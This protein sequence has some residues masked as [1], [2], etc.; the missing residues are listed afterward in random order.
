MSVDGLSAAGTPRRPVGGSSF[1]VILSA[2]PAIGWPEK[3][4]S[5]RA[6]P[7]GGRGIIGIMALRGFPNADRSGL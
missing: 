4:A 2:S 5:G 1:S 3:W 7:S 6:A